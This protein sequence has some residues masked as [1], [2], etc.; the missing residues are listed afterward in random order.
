MQF[1]T[2][3]LTLRKQNRLSQADAV[4]IIQAADK[5]LEKTDEATLSRWENAHTQ[6]S[7]LKQAY[8]LRAFDNADAIMSARVHSAFSPSKQRKILEQLSLR[9]RHYGGADMPYC[10]SL[11]QAEYYERKPVSDDD[12]ALIT[13]F[14]SYAVG[15][16]PI[17]SDSLQVESSSLLT[18]YHGKVF[19][20]RMLLGHSLIYTA[21][22]GKIKQQHGLKYQLKELDIGNDNARCLVIDSIYSSHKNL[23]LSIIP[24]FI[25]ALYQSK[26]DYLLYRVYQSTTAKMLMSYGAVLFSLGKEEE[27]SIRIDGKCYQWACYLIAANNILVS[28][29]AALLPEQMPIELIERQVQP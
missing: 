25:T 7:L 29:A 15:D 17:T 19:G 20:H 3:L 12:I 1:S 24:R 27:S 2:A 26:A 21:L 14:Y 6:P 18:T 8:I 10:D 9:Y 13:Y 5:Q 22:L 23:F 28:S 4:E 16:A 11:T